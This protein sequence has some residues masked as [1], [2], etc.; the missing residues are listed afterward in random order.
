MKKVYVGFKL[1]SM[2]LNNLNLEIG[3]WIVVKEFVVILIFLR[4]LF[5]FCVLSF[6]KLFRNCLSFMEWVKLVVLNCK[7]KWV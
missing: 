7:F 1:K 5:I 3:V 2:L 4:Y 6:F